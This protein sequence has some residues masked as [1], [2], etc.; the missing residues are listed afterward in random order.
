MSSPSSTRETCATVPPSVLLHGRGAHYVFSY[1]DSMNHLWERS[2]QPREPEN[3]L[4]IIHIVNHL[5]SS[6]FLPLS[7]APEQ[8]EAKWIIGIL[9]RSLKRFGD[10]AA[11][12][13]APLSVA[14]ATQRFMPTMQTSAISRSDVPSSVAQSLGQTLNSVL[15]I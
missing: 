1:F 13:L 6:G 7:L 11:M 5:Q 12:E 14:A 3:T 2:E 9:P 4:G 15:E 10:R 8:S